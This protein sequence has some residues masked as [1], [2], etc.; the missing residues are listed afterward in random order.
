MRLF[1][2]DFEPSARRG[3]QELSLLDE[4][5]D[6]AKRGHEVTLGYVIEGDLLPR[7]EAAGVATLRLP[8]IALGEGAGRIPALGR[9]AR[10]ALL[11]ARTKPDVVCINQYLDTLFGSMV[12]R[13]RH[14]PLVCHLRLFPPDRFCGQWRIGLRAVTRFIAV[15]GAVRDAWVDR[16]VEPTT[17]D[18]V[19]DG[20]D[21]E[22]FRPTPDRAAI[23]RALG[24][25]EDAFVVAFAGRLDRGKHLEALIS[26]FAELGLPASEARLLIAGRPVHH[27]TP[28][29]GERY[30]AGLRALAAE[31][32]VADAVHWLGSRPDVPDIM[33]AADVTALFTLY[34]DALPRAIY[35][36]LA[37]G[38]PAVAQ[39]DGGTLEVLTGEFER[40]AFDARVPGDAL[41]IL[42]SLRGW[43]SSDPGL[44]VRAR[45]HA[46]RQFGKVAMV[47]GIERS[48][49]RAAGSARLR[50]GPRGAPLRAYHPLVP[51]HLAEQREG[52]P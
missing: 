39:R 37:C 16:G 5:I 23:R 46:E 24:V 35:E 10:S 34:P 29:D 6:L 41:R 32:G 43:Q 21:L 14:A 47:D 7:Y 8:G 20:I 3:G 49:R 15:S 12:A 25:P 51:L 36:S 48:L 13:L 45:A 40:F 33:S 50:A 2:Y 42:R 19:H 11:A 22:R 31:R 9:L 30:V 1:F 18:V 26:T 38:T 17:I 27:A 52:A 44:G 28:E 4:C